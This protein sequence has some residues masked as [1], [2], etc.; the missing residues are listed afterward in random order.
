MIH[1]VGSMAQEC[2]GLEQASSLV[3]GHSVVVEQ[4]VGMLLPPIT[5]HE[6]PHQQDTSPQRPT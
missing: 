1:V 2:T 6:Q 4:R 5:T 3:D